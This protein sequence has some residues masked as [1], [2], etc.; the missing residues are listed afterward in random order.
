MRRARLNWHN[1]SSSDPEEAQKRFEYERNKQILQIEDLQRYSIQTLLIEDYDEVGSIL[2][3]IE[4]RS[5]TGTSSSP[6][7]RTSSESLVNRDCANCACASARASS[8]ATAG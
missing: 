2:Q 6:A 3:A 4:E 8:S 5:P 1:P 7:A